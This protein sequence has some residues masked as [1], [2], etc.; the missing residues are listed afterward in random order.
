MLGGLGLLALLL[1]EELCR[2]A[3][4]LFSVGGGSGDGEGGRKV[5]MSKEKMKEKVE[6]DGKEER[7]R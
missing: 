5:G 1:P 4:A 3:A 6:E 7:R 2:A